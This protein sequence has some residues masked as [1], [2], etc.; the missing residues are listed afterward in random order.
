MTKALVVER[1]KI[2]AVNAKFLELAFEK[3]KWNKID[4]CPWRSEFPYCPEV[5]F[6]IGHDD[7]N[8]YLHYRVKEEFV[9]GQYIR[10]NEN[11]WEDS[12]VE[13]FLSLDGK[14]TY[15]NFEFNVLATGLIGYGSAI[16]SERNRLS[17]EDIES[18]DAYVNLSKMAGVK[19]WDSYLVVPKAIFGEVDFSGN[20]FH[21]NFYKCGDG[22]PK[23]H[24]LAWNS[25]END[26]PNFHMPA[27]FG[28]L[29]FR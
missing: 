16:K 20:T 14:R 6:Q 11:V 10:P 1:L 22:L 4:Q 7:T 25:I 21:G 23:P 5:M 12:C 19:T 29:S 9:K 27:Y 13:F 26:K 28:E 17:T 8:I 24:F 3:E 15:Y 2:E 18:V